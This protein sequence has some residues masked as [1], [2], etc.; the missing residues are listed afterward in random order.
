MN[1]AIHI[2]IFI[3]FLLP[4]QIV[5]SQ[6]DDRLKDLERE[7]F[8]LERKIQ[9]ARHFINLFD[10]L[11]LQQIFQQADIQFKLA[12]E[13]YQAQQYIKSRTHIKMSYLY[14]TQ[15]YQK[16]K[17]NQYIRGRFRE[18]LD[19]KIQEAEQIVSQ[20]QNP[21]AAKLLNR[22]RYFRQRS[23]QLFQSDRPEA[24]LKN[25]FIAIFFAESAIRIAS[26]QDLIEIKNLERHFE[27]SRTLLNQVEEIAH[28]NRNNTANDLINRSRRE[29]QS[30]QRHYDQK[31]NREAYQKIQIVNRLLYRALDLLEINSAA[32]NE[33]LETELHLLEGKINELQSLSQ[34]NNA[35]DMRRI[36]E[37]LIFLTTAARQKYQHQDYT[38]A[39]QRILLANRLLYQLER[40]VK[41]LSPTTQ[42]QV[43]NQLQ[44]AEIMLQ[45]LDENQFNN[46][47]YLQLLDLLQKNYQKAREEYERENHIKSLH[48]LKFFNGLA[49]KLDQMKSSEK[50]QN[51]RIE[52]VEEGLKRLKNLI[53]NPPESIKEDEILSIKYN[54]A[55]K[56]YEI[57]QDACEQQNYVACHQI[58]RLATNLLTQ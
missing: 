31:Q 18:I 29:L 41:S 33:R 11:E 38:G 9:E 54:Y 16:L 28:V 51:E 48:F 30:A 2:I 20:S 37:R 56:L 40:R 14:L 39:R 58:S 46:P 22:A 3:C 49:L 8:R 57:A 44:T 5:L 32:M 45:S 21:E 15:I 19:Q 27:N 34:K 35:E 24:M 13:A 23:F 50:L 36:Y 55:I 26:G 10:N 53:D 43:R 25:Y 17:N 1:R 6:Q 12:R 42:E 52:T 7:L 4:H 47:I